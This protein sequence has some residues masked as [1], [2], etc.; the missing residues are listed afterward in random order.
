MSLTYGSNKNVYLPKII[1]KVSQETQ[2]PFYI[3]PHIKTAS[4]VLLGCCIMHQV[5]FP[6]IYSHYYLV[7]LYPSLAS[8]ISLTFISELREAYHQIVPIFFW[9]QIIPG[10]SLKCK[11]HIIYWANKQQNLLSVIQS[12][13][14]N[15]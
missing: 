8:P 15:N 11:K 1:K 4:P 14:V 10:V 7:A 13:A 2:F 6:P 12:V 3:S 9:L 5:S